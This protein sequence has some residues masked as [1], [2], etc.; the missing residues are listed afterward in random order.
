MRAATI[1]ALTGP[2]AVEVHEW[3]EPAPTASQVLIDVEYS[4]VVFP[5]V[6]QTR[7]EYQSRP[8]VPFIP[9]W[10]VSGVV[11]PT[12]MGSRPGREWRPCRL[13]EASPRPL[14]SMRRCFRFPTAYPSTR[15][16]HCHSTT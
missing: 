9:G 2:E 15:W 3:P 13:S 8:D 12:P 7:G 1:T 11:R 6:L 5:D 14:R 10:E 16:R 4:G